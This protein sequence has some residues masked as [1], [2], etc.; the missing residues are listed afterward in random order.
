M[1]RAFCNSKGVPLRLYLHQ[2]DKALIAAL[3]MIKQIEEGGGALK[4]LIIQLL[5]RITT[6][7]AVVVPEVEDA[8]CV[9]ISEPNEKNA[10][11]L[12]KRLAVLDR[13]VPGTTHSLSH[14]EDDPKSPR[15][16]GA[17]AP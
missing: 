1:Q 15:N 9:V 17:G 6:E 4:Y 8:P 3:S 16:E 10:I 5:R 7:F 13:D 12:Q 14:P 11:K 2:D